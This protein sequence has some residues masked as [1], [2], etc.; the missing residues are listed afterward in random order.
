MGVCGAIGIA[1]IIWFFMTN[2]PKTEAKSPAASPNPY[3]TIEFVP[4]YPAGYVSAE[5]PYP[6]QMSPTVGTAP[7]TYST[8]DE[9][10]GSFQP[11][12]TYPG[13]YQSSEGRYPGQAAQY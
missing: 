3:N 2:E 12:G 1:L 5:M 4:V 6:N 9:R 7:M 10:Q 13:L 11:Y 8:D